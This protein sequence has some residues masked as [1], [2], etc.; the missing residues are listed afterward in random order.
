MTNK[1]AYKLLFDY[2]YSY[3]ESNNSIYY[4]P[5][6]DLHGTFN[7]HDCNCMKRLKI[8][9]LSQNEIDERIDKYLQAQE[10]NNGLYV[11]SVKMYGHIN[12][13][14]CESKNAVTP[15]SPFHWGSDD[16]YS[17]YCKKSDIEKTKKQLIS[18]CLAKHDEKIIKATKNKKQFLKMIEQNDIND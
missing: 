4:Y 7:G 5:C 12:V 6:D 9:Y 15:N 1:E 18:L 14:P 16:N 2:P 10:L 11:V 8:K 17:M 13:S 3:D